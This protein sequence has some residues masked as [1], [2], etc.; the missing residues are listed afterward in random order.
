M[1]GITE[2]VEALR[3]WM[4][5]G[6]EVTQ[7]LNEYNTKY[8]DEVTMSAKHHEEI[9]STQKKLLNEVKNLVILME[10][11]GDQFMEESNDRF[12]LI[13]KLIMSSKI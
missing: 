4:V 3:R 7:L 8:C 12:T 2:N 1:I 13:T 5:A 6:P 11:I 10:E 9:Q